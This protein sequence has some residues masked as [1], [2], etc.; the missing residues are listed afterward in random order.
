MHQH[1]YLPAAPIRA[2]IPISFV[3]GV[4]YILLAQ[5][6][7][8]SANI[9][10]L[11]S[12]PHHNVSSY[13]WFLIIGLEVQYV[14]KIKKPTLINRNPHQVVQVLNEELSIIELA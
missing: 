13:H 8:Y 3:L 12:S 11:M 7:D 10:A 9:P 1:P 14:L 4:L 5:T 2:Y 6:L